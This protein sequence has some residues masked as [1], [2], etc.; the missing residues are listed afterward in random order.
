[1]SGNHSEPR[2]AAV[3]CRFTSPPRRASTGA[4]GSTTVIGADAFARWWVSASSHKRVAIDVS[5]LS[6]YALDGESLE[7]LLRASP[8]LLASSVVTEEPH[9]RV[10]ESASIA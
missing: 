3:G 5:H 8:Q 7:A 4:C 10:C 9:D 6:T 1:M 2:S